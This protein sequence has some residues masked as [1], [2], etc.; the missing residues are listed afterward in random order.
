[1]NVRNS[2][3]F[4]QVFEES[5]RHK[6]GISEDQVLQVLNAPEAK[7]SLRLDDVELC[8][9]AKSVKFGFRNEVL[10]VCTRVQHSDLYVD[11][12]FRILLSPSENVSLPE[13][14]IMLQSLAMRFGLLVRIGTQLNKFV[15]SEEIVFDQEPV[16]P[17][18][19][20]EILNPENHSCAS[21]IW[22]RSQR[23]SDKFTIKCALAY[24]IDIT[25]YSKWVLP[26][27][28]SQG[29]SIAIAPQIG[30][31]ATDRDLLCAAGTIVLRTRY[32]EIGG[33]KAG[34]LFQVKDRGYIL[35]AGF[36]D[37]AF[38][39]QRNQDRLALALDP[40]KD[41]EDEIMCAAVWEPTRLGVYIVGRTRSQPAPETRNRF[42]Q[43][44]ATLPPNSLISWARQ[45]AIAPSQVFNSDSEFYRAVTEA[46]QG[47]NEKVSTLGMH[48]AFWNISYEGRRIV[49]RT[50]KHETEIHPTMHGLLH[51]IKIAKNLEIIPEYPI[52]GGRL[53]F[54][55]IGTLHDGKHV[56]AC[57]EFKHAHSQDVFH[58]LLSQLPA[59]MR[60]K[61]SNYGV[62]CVMNFKGPH[63]DQPK[64][65]DIDAL[66][67]ELTNRSSRVGI[68]NIRVL[69]LDL[70]FPT[71]P[72]R[73]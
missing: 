31:H 59:Y 55:V 16:S 36:T 40:R 60:G 58:G 62:Y 25:E 5:C 27:E 23:V 3:H 73:A 20:V 52:S 64:E 13:P 29:P 15:M 17:A 51:D 9:F 33:E 53:D 6:F 70:A 39:I 45:E 24:A 11:L 56:T 66:H 42:L 21:S 4:T 22:I 61:G 26:E 12:A 72:S 67:F 46:L 8:F 2:V 57:V 38:Y 10:L 68:S 35:E 65:Y 28:D 18:K 37:R 49:S 69:V 30:G 50:P 41:S 63:F 44:T 34:Y 32:S 19:I 71:S 7:Q 47:V 48:S 43:T 14:L 54:L 1:M